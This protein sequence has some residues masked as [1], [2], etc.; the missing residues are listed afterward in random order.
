MEVIYS[1]N[2]FGRPYVLPEGVP[3]ERV[4]AL[5]KAF[6]ATMG[7]PALIAEANKAGMELG[8]RDGEEVQALV[9]KL[10]ALPPNVIARTKKAMIYKA[11][12]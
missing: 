12:K 7:D 1:Q 2:M 10:Y 6:M 9:A 4:T 11:P 8:A 3:A 5:R